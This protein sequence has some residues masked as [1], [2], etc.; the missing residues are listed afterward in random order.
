MNPTEK[1]L[2]AARLIAEVLPTLDTTEAVCTCCGH[3]S[4]RNW[5][6]HQL[7]ERMREMPR[8]LQDCARLLTRA[9]GTAPADHR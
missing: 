4:K 5:T 7:Q 1:L 3:K 2:E 9:Q 6:E 8:K